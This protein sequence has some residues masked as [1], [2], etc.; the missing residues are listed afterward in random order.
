MS[1][2]PP[3]TGTGP[4]DAVESLIRRGMAARRE[5]RPDEAMRHMKAAVRLARF[6]E[7]PL[8]LARALHG[9]ANVERDGGNA[10]AAVALYLEAVP[11]CRQGDDPLI[12]A[13]TARHLGDVLR[14][15]GEFNKAA[16]CYAE[17]LAVYR[18]DPA[19]PPLD[20]ANAVR[21]AAILCEAQNEPDQARQ[22]WLEA[23]DL[24]GVAGVEAGV[25]ESASHLERLR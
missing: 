17:A 1:D 20:A 3:E 13:H 5:D 10:H 2:I 22:L 24:Y 9:Q 19:A 16:Q 11:L 4:R 18:A 12:L 15:L 14:E 21:S 8:A 23:R 7:D 6:G 25:S